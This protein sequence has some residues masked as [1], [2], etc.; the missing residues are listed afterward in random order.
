MIRQSPQKQGLNVTFNTTEDCNLR[1]KYCY[2]INKR[3]FHLEL[4]KAKKFIDI[5]L[6]DPDPCLLNDS[7]K[8]SRVYSLGIILD[9]IGGDALM[10][11]DLLDKILT[12]WVQQ[13]NTVDTPN[14]KIWRYT[15]R[16][17]I[18]SNGTLFG[19][20]DVRAFCEKWKDNLSLGVSIDGCPEIHDAYRVFPDGKGSMDA[21]LENWEWYQRTFPNNGI[22]TKATCSKAS[23]PYLYDSLVFMHEK[24]GMSQINQ[25][26]IMEDM[27]LEDAD[28][29]LLDEQLH[30]CADYVL[31]HCDELYWSMLGSH[32]VSAHKSTGDDWEKQGQCGSGAMPALAI[33]G[34]I[35]PCFRWLPHTQQEAGVMSVGDVENGFNHKENFKKVR[36]GAYRCNCTRE[37]KCRDCEYES[38]C[39][40]CIGGCYAEFGDFI[41]TT[42]ICEVAKLQVKWARYYWTKYLE[43]K[44]KPIPEDWST[45]MGG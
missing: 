3:P 35:Y 29:R 45:F 23:I 5:L 13:V 2:E 18:S 39:P 40:Y 7:D 41:R 4:D 19:Q 20:P 26:F 43:M 38:A 25:N 9:F 17:S 28:Y 34:R 31:E 44:G 37:E 36:E 32:I 14:A 21:I 42:H 6:H 15:W 33:D 12:Y 1:C 8:L 27:H 10:N 22:S 24:L 11:V 30:K 16:A